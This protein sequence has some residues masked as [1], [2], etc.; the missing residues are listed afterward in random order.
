MITVDLNCDL[1]EGAGHDAAL[2]PWVSSANVACGAHA[3]DR[4]TM[5][6]TVALARAHRVVIGAHPGYADRIHFGRKELTLSSAEVRA[7]IETQVRA[8]AAL[9]E[10]RYVKPHGALY[11][12]AAREATV[13]EAVAAGV[14]A[15][16]T[17]LVLVGLAGGASLAAGRAAGLR[18]VAEVFA[19]RRYE[20]DGTLTPRSVPG[21]VIEDDRVAVAQ[22][23]TLVCEGRVRARTG[24]WVA[25]QADTLCLHGDGLHAVGFAR[26]VRSA[27]VEAG[28]AVRAFC[29]W[30]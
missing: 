17:T 2:M 1:G 29:P 11:N 20:A 30:R 22:A 3:G 23:L 21:A 28:V 7:L 26:S 27:L 19:D 8:L 13:A 15:V 10:V 16:D 6:A 24:E 5:A 18:V 25:V 14:G 9:A 4:A 12:Q